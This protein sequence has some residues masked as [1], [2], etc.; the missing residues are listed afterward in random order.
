MPGQPHR[1]TAYDVAVIGQ[2]Y[3]PIPALA[4]LAAA[5]AALFRPVRGW[6][7]RPTPPTPPPRW[8]Q[9]AAVARPARPPLAA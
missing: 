3:G 9:P 4:E 2:W 1:R 8:P 6:R 5:P 7:R